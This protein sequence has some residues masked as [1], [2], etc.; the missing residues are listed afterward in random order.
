[1]ILKI[2]KNLNRKKISRLDEE[3]INKDYTYELLNSITL[4][5]K[6]RLENAEILILKELNKKNK[7]EEV[8]NEN[9]KPKG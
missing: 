6:Q 4:I 7:I 9:V 3:N 1:M 5:E 8:N 2:E